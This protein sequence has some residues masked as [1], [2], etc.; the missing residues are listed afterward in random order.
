MLLDFADPAEGPQEVWRC[1]GCGREMLFDPER[2]AEDQRLIDRI[3]Q[4]EGS[5]VRVGR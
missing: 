5:R 4:E 1:L 3:L 2:R